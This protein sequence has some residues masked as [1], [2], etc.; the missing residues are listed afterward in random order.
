M[1]LMGDRLF[2]MPG[3]EMCYFYSEIGLHCRT[4]NFKCPALCVN[5]DWTVD[6]TKLK[7]QWAKEN[8]R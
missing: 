2:K 8:P 3:P 7:A 1:N 5:V 6:T 4:E